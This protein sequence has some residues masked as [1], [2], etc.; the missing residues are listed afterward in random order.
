MHT[1]GKL[2]L[3]LTS[4]SARYFLEMLN[5]SLPTEFRFYFSILSLFSVNAQ[6]NC[7]LS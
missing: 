2:Q 7:M 5:V 4:A 3:N 1:Q 6:T